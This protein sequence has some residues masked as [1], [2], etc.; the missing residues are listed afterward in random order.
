[1]LTKVEDGKP[2]LKS[3][4]ARACTTE[5]ESGAV[6]PLRTHNQDA[7]YH[8]LDRHLHYLLARTTAGVS[9]AACANAYFDWAIHLASSPGRQLELL[10]EAIHQWTRLADFTKAAA[11]AGADA[12]PCILPRP[13]DKRFRS[14]H[15][16]E[17]PFNVYGQSFLLWE[18]WWHSAVTGVRG[19]ERQNAERLDFILR[20]VLDVFAPTNSLLTNPDVLLRTQA[21]AGFN[22]VRGLWNYLE[23]LKRLRDREGPDGSENY[24]VGEAVAV[25]PGKVIFRNHLIELIQYSPTTSEVHPEPILIIPAWIMKFYILDLR[26]E[27]SLVKYLTGQG[28]T[29]FMVSWHNP[30]EEDRDTNFEDY[31]RLGVMAAIDAVSKVV[32]G[33]KIH[34]AGYCLGG[35]LLATAAAAMALDN[36]DR[37]K[38]VT[39]LAA[40]ADFRE[41]GELTLF[42]DE[43]Q[44]S[45]LEDM[46]QEQGFLDSTQMAGAFQLLRSNDLIWS[47][48]INR[49]LLGERKPAFDL[50]A[51]NADAT[52]M[53]YRMHSDYLRSLFLNNDLAEGRYTVNGRAIALTDL[54]MPV[55]ALG[56][57]TDHVAPWRSVYKFNILC[58]TDVTFVLTSGGHNAGVV[59][60]P[61]SPGRSYRMATKFETDS[62]ESPDAWHANAPKFEGSWWSAWTGWLSERS[63]RMTKPPSMGASGDGLEPLE[64]AP[65]T[66]V[67]QR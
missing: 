37:L 16:K 53:P 4:P 48:V 58:D 34:A 44:I 50:L 41:A 49:Y 59:S 2:E 26:P 67:Y 22:L 3:A 27:N 32:G 6:E 31:R 8:N 47:H 38:T 15:W 62:F 35:T 60:P 42:I 9:P 1:M 11:S 14:E 10:G 24:R 23:D 45:F 52:R 55:F 56:T 28:F 30:G 18:E 66:Y 29:V 54:R 46:M 65:G 64:N 13:N 19:V 5:S 57:E 25:T 20:Q 17:F 51:W 40:Q 39:F 12:T 7:F 63:S 21:E 43:S 33:Q 36:D 61:G